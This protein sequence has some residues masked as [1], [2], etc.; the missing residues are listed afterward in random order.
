MQEVHVEDA[1]HLFVVIDFVIVIDPIKVVLQKVCCL[2]KD[3]LFLVQR[4]HQKDLQLRMLSK[5]TIYC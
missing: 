4:K 5:E 2:K 1:Q 3:M